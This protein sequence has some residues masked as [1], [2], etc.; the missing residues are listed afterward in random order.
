M[1]VRLMGIKSQFEN[2]KNFWRWMV[3]MVAQQYDYRECNG[4]RTLKMVEV[5]NFILYVFYHN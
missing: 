4:T 5:V 1:R 3:V 2:T